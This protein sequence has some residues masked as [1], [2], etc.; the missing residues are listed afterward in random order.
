MFNYTPLVIGGAD[1]NKQLT[2]IKQTQT[3][4]FPIRKKSFWIRA[5]PD[6]K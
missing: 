4:I 5:A 2:N 3:G 1:K 6:P